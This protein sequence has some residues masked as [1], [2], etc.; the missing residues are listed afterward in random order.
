MKVQTHECY[1]LAM[2]PFIQILA[3]IAPS[4]GE[5][6]YYERVLKN[7]TSRSVNGVVLALLVL[8]L[9][10]NIILATL[11]LKAKKSKETEIQKQ[12]DTGSIT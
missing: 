5:V 11:V 2:V 1:T 10:V 8:S 9:L 12:N 7:E 6:D 3:D 4:P